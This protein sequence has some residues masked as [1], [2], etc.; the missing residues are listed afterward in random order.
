VNEKTEAFRRLFSDTPELLRHSTIREALE[1][2]RH[3]DQSLESALAELVKQL[4]R[5]EFQ[6]VKAASMERE[7]DDLRVFQQLAAERIASQTGGHE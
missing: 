4:V 3:G 5:D 2:Y 1:A 7:R 6:L